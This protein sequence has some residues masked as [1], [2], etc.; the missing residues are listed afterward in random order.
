MHND[1]GSERWAPDQ[2]GE[3]QRVWSLAE[4]GAEGETQFIKNMVRFREQ[5]GMTQGGLANMLRY[6]GITGMHQTTL[7]RIEKGERAIKLHEAL[8]IARALDSTVEQLLQPTDS[9][10]SIQEVYRVARE[11]DEIERNM[12]KQ[13]ERAV[14]LMKEHSR[15]VGQVVEILEEADLSVT[16]L[17]RLQFTL[18]SVGRKIDQGI[19]SFLTSVTRYFENSHREDP[20]G[21]H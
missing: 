14:E 8:A 12:A 4:L 6:S 21:E 11:L 20:H 3:L 18:G 1:D 7:S 19:Y 9:Y 5:K 15:N 13:L 17:E 2:N 16:E 10:A